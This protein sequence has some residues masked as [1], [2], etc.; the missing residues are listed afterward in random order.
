MK[1]TKPMAQILEALNAAVKVDPMR[2]LEALCETRVPVSGA[3]V[4]REDLPFVALEEDDKLWLGFIGV[5]SGCLKLALDLPDDVRL[6]AH[7][8]EHILTHFS[9][10]QRGSE[11]YSEMKP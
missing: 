6:V 7:Y 11:K 9:F 3:L 2:A 5:L 8:D 10:V 1:L 4:D